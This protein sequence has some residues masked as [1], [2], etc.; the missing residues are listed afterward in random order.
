MKSP[1]TYS[2]LHL[3]GFLLFLRE[4]LTCLL[5]ATS[6]CMG[7]V[8]L[9]SPVSSPNSCSLWGSAFSGYPDILLVLQMHHMLSCA[10][11]LQQ[12]IAALNLDWSLLTLHYQG[13]LSHPFYLC[14]TIAYLEMPVLPS[15]IR[16]RFLDITYQMWCSYHSCFTKL[17]L[18]FF[19]SCQSFLLDS[20]SQG[21]ML[22]L[23][24][25]WCQSKT[26]I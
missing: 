26:S 20:L 18:W 12:E 14:S 17:I 16:F 10:G 22:L 21:L 24:V 5:V 4:R 15:L 3:N 7:S 9:S 19:H 2:L 1:T 25:F 11:S 6:S 13:T 23:T 8:L